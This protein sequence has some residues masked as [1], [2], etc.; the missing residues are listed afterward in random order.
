M[1]QPSPA[2]HW[3]P[4]GVA[5]GSL[6]ILAV[7][8][9]HYSGNAWPHYWKP[10]VLLDFVLWSSLVVATAWVLR[11]QGGPRAA[12]ALLG[13]ML[14]YLLYGAGLGA[15]ASVVL[16]LASSWALGELALKLLFTTRTP[17]LSLEAPL[18]L[19]LA[20]HLALFGLLIHYP[21]ND[22][23]L[24][25]AILLTPLLAGGKLIFK[26]RHDVTQPIQASVTRLSQ[27]PF[28]SLTSAAVLIGYVSRF[29]LFPTVA[30]DDNALHLRL[31][32]ELLFQ[33]RYTFDVSR[34][35][36]SVAPFAVDLQHGIVS[37]VAGT[38]ARSA[39]N[40]AFLALLLRQVWWLSGLVLNDERARLLILTLFAST[41][42]LANLLTSLQTELFLGLLATAGVRLL[43]SSPTSARGNGVALLA[44]GAMACATKL[45]G[46]VLGVCLLLGHAIQGPSFRQSW[47][48]IRPLALSVVMLALAFTA[49]H[50]YLVA[51][52]VTGNPLFPLY[53]GIFRSSY[54]PPVNFSDTR[55]VKGFNLNSYWSS[56]FQTSQ[57]FESKNFVAGFQY[58]LLLPPALLVFGAR[59]PRRITLG[60]LI[61]LCGFGLAM[62]SATQYWRYLFPI[63]P[64]GSV[65]IAS[66]FIGTS[67][68]NASVL[69]YMLGVYI[70]INLYFL[71]GISWFFENSPQQSYTEN[72]RTQVAER[73]APG[74]QITAYINANHPGNHVLYDADVPFGA[75]LNGTP[76][77]ITWYAPARADRFQQSKTIDDI[78]RFMQDERIRLVVWDMA[79]VSQ[80]NDARGLLRTY[81]SRFG[82]PEYQVGSIVL[83]KLADKEQ[84]YQSVF[85]ADTTLS[86]QGATQQARSLAT[87]PTQGAGMA[88][89]TAQFSCTRANGN[90]IA[91]I[92]WSVGAPYYRQV[93]CGTTLTHF[94]E[95]LPI[96]AGASTGEVLVSVNGETEAQLSQIQIEI[97]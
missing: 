71:P 35:I 61:P 40:L 20:L 32:T 27:L 95:A 77:Y 53:N 79:P 50:A 55:Y 37:L 3:L 58:L 25:L 96:P 11:R 33:Q 80:A 38:D 15:S 70:A 60:L 43:L 23:L 19:G 83:Y 31:W 88:R 74:K 13:A 2:R 7:A 45:P 57:F 94:E 59:M 86:G 84:T 69:R 16:F 26:G 65:A 42:M 10:R 30:Y 34:Q 46:A 87:F 91:Q 68:R 62:Y 44:V 48:G 56:F 24:Y 39:L 67:A 66:L 14:L 47:Q 97:K 29:A 21:I 22:R 85:S 81:L 75:S 64:L 52:K 1:L 63:L 18:F 76:T 82:L 5:L 9:V 90:F 8:L 17:Q 28:W 6:A 41:P 92:N 78:A 93:S 4:P 36:W 54:F 73:L 89:Y 51:W 49:F 72:G 12:Q